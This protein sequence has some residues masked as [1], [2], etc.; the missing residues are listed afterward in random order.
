[1]KNLILF[2]KAPVPGRVKTRLVPPLTHEE[3][4]RLYRGWSRE[5]YRSVRELDGVRVEV[6]YESH[7][8][9][10]TPDW[11]DL[12]RDRVP[13]FEQERGDL[14]RR[15]VQAFSRAFESGQER[16]AVIG[17]DSPGL[18][19]QHIRETFAA[20]EGHDLV[21]GPTQDGG[22]YLVGLRKRVI[23]R[24]FEGIPWSTTGVFTN[25]VKVAAEMGLRLHLLPEYFDIDRPEDLKRIKEDKHYVRGI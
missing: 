14:G 24:I 13:F 17:S 1:M 12:G 9:F 22:Y 10:P 3:A 23:Q 19:L 4:C 5:I 25:T 16:V 2:V 20:L 21:L 8:A 7:P 15:L 6:A 11:L 18:P